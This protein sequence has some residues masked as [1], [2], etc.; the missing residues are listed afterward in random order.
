[1]VVP[2]GLA[3]VRII[4]PG[5]DVQKT[6]NKAQASVK[7]ILLWTMLS[8]TIVILLGLLWLGL[9][10]YIIVRLITG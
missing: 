9:F 5:L 7:R 4:T 3:L 6:R 2:I 10:I 8:L 1:V